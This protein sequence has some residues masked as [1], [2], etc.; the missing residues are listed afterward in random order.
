MWLL[1]F[2]CDFSVP[3]LHHFLKFCRGVIMGTITKR[4]TKDGQT[5]YRAA[6]R[7]NKNG[8]KYSQSAT[9]SKQNLAA[10]WLKNERLKLN[11]TP[12]AYTAP[13]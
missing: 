6:I 4:K 10:A 9:F 11:L 12:I 5:R 3:Y 8:V 13:P 1:A 7:I 2:I